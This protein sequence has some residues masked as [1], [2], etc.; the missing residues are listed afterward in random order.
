[1]TENDAVAMP[2]LAWRRQFTPVR[3]EGG[4]G[5]VGEHLTHAVF[6]EGKTRQGSFIYIACYIHKATQGAL[7]D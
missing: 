3:A 6:K 7:H 5:G 4:E 2:S 1:M